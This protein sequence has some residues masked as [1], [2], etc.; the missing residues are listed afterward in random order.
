MSPRPEIKHILLTC[1]NNDDDDDDD[2]FIAINSV[3]KI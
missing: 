1:D 3:G 2:S